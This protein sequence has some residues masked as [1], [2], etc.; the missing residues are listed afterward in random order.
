LDIVINELG[1]KY[2]TRQEQKIN[3]DIVIHKVETIDFLIDNNSLLDLLV[4]E[5]GGHND[6]MGCFAKRE[7]RMN[8]NSKNK[9][10]LK[11]KPETINGRMA[12]YVCPECADI[13]CGAYCCEIKKTN[14][15]YVWKNFAYENY[16]EDAKLLEN[17][18]SFYFNKNKYEDIIFELSKNMN[19]KFIII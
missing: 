6:F 17:I 7:K 5:Y 9:L 13:G 12:I 1:Y 16:H 14:E 2:F 3:G 15:Y 11:I 19:K 18:G 4:R 10:L 8:E